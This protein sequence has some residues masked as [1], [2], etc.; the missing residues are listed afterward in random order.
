M[1]GGVGK[2]T[3]ATLLGLVLAENRGDRVIALDANPD[4]GTLADRLTGESAV[5]V[6]ELVRDLDR[7]DS[8]AA[9]VALHQPG[10]P[11]AGARVRAGP[12]AAGGLQPRRVRAASAPCWSA[13][14]TSS[15]PTRAPGSCIRRWP[16]TWPGRTAWSSSARRPST[17]PAGP[18]RRSTGC[19]A[20]GTAPLASG[21]GGRAE[22]RPRPAPRWTATRIR[23]HFAD[24]LPGGRGDPARPAAGR[25]RAGR[26]GAPAPG[27]PGRPRSSWPRWSPTTSRPDPR[28]PACSPRRSRVLRCALV[29]LRTPACADS[30]IRL[31]LDCSTMLPFVHQHG[32]RRPR[33]SMNPSPSSSSPPS[34]APDRPR[35][36]ARW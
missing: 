15:S 36:C 3:V 22:Q 6:R 21:R 8:W 19:G 31:L 18:A 10:R 16:G 26:A 11:A 13:T 2:T 32:Y 28:R 5:T 25:R 9:V 12:A 14:S 27:H 7:I 4:A 20:T 1:K 17:A 24:A 35:V 33:R 23:E 30:S 29:L 34:A